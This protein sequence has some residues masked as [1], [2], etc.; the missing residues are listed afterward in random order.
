MHWKHNWKGII[1]ICSKNLWFDMGKQA[2]RYLIIVDT[3]AGYLCDI[4]V[5]KKIKYPVRMIKPS[6]SKLYSAKPKHFLE[7]Q[8]VARRKWFY[9]Q[10]NLG[11]K[12]KFVFWETSQ[13]F[14]NGHCGSLR[15]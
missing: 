13:S 1:I 5:G 15:N 3:Q 14:G 2:I 11:N 12:I 7:C 6:T 8:W 10:M 4:P 9:G